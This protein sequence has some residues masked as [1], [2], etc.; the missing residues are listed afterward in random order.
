[1]PV[2]AAAVAKAVP[3]GGLPEPTAR[4][5]GQ[6]IDAVINGKRKTSADAKFCR[7]VKDNLLHLSKWDWTLTHEE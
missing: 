1:M 2:A 6:I 5:S 4:K 3:L 7:K